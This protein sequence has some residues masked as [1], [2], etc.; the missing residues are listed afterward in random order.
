MDPN[1]TLLDLNKTS[2]PRR[3]GDGPTSSLS[4]SATGTLTPQAR[5]WTGTCF[6]QPPV[7]GA[8]PAGAGMDRGRGGG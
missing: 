5:G 1:K 8:Y 7:V 4:S 6:Q 3:R 2:L